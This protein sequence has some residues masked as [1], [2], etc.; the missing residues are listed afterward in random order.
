MLAPKLA[1]Y[2]QSVFR[3]TYLHILHVFAHIYIYL[4]T[5]AYICAGDIDNAASVDG[6]VAR[7]DSPA[8][9][10]QHRVPAAISEQ[11]WRHL[12]AVRD[13]PRLHDGHRVWLVWRRCSLR[14][15]CRP[16]VCCGCG[17]WQWRWSC[18][19]YYQRS[20]LSCLCRPCYML[21]LSRCKF[22]LLS[23]PSSISQSNLINKLECLMLREQP[24]SVQS[25]QNRSW[26]VDNYSKMSGNYWWKNYV[27]SMWQKSVIIVGHFYC[28]HYTV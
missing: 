4:H 26:Y 27:F 25:P 16:A 21:Q 8:P 10:D 13:M 9:R 6:R 19:V 3:C 11:W 2:M 18:H 24:D 22:G 5:F 17:M 15:L 23:S 14:S 20:V 1:V 7:L 12:P 28:A